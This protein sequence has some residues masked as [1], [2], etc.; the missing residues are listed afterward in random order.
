MFNLPIL[1]LELVK[2]SRKRGVEDSLECDR[3]RQESTRIAGHEMKRPGH[4]VR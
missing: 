2:N 3:E 4:F 1:L